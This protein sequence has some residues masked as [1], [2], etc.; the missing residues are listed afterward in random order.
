[1]PPP[2]SPKTF[3]LKEALQAYYQE[4]GWFKTGVPETDDVF[5][6]PQ[7]VTRAQMPLTNI[8]TILGGEQL[9]LLFSGPGTVRIQPIYPKQMFARTSVSYHGKRS[10]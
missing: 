10:Q 1:M 5:L 9:V 2:P 7:T 8:P 3:P 4:N 6:F